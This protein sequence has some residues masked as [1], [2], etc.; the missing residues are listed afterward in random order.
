MATINGKSLDLLFGSPSGPHLPSNPSLESHVIVFCGM[1]SKWELMISCFSEHVFG[2]LQVIVLTSVTNH[3]VAYG[4]TV[5]WKTAHL[6]TPYNHC[7]FL[8]QYSCR[9]KFCTG[10]YKYLSSVATSV[11]S[12][13]VE[14]VVVKDVTHVCHT[15]RRKW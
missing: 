10:G 6:S 8:W 11:Y 1:C 7:N 4:H 15:C 2:M 13:G 12:R 3:S 14:C 5:H 9:Y